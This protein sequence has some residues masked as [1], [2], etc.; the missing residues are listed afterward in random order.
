MCQLSA[1]VLS[2]QIP[3]VLS[4][5]FQLQNKRVCVSKF[6]ANN[7]ANQFSCEVNHGYTDLFVCLFV[8]YK[9]QA[10]SCVVVFRLTIF[11]QKCNNFGNNIYKVIKNKPRRIS[12]VG[13]VLAC[14]Q[15]GVGFEFGPHRV[16]LEM[17]NVVPTAAL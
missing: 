12:E 11:V 3:D 2:L 13:N 10:L 17:L 4:I 1:I 8:T 6:C 9:K 7:F 15:G 16:I 14:C 5:Q